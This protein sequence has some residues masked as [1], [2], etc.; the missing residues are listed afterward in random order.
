MRDVLPCR[1]RPVSESHARIKTTCPGSTHLGETGCKEHTFK[2]L[3]H[4]LKEL[5][6]MGSLQ[7]INL[8][9]RVQILGPGSRKQNEQ[10]FTTANQLIASKKLCYSF[11]SISFSLTAEA[12]SSLCQ[13]AATQCK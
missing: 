13:A 12:P 7:N 6:H 3:A 5:I 9:D 4:L 11:Q 1:C 10:Y 8:Q 2:E